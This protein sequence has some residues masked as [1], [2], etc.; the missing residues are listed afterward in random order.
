MN[1]DTP[2]SLALKILAIY[3]EEWADLFPNAQVVDGGDV[4][5]VF[6]DSQSKEVRNH[7]SKVYPIS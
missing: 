3:Q 7:Y 6:N 2:P 5:F 4:F 1:G